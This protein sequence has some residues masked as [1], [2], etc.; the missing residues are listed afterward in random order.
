[1]GLFAPPGVIVAASEIVPE[2]PLILVRLR[3]KLPELP[4]FIVID[5]GMEI[6]VKSGE[7]ALAIWTNSVTL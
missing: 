2:K 5:D 6:I 7:G 1:M 3:L 4:R